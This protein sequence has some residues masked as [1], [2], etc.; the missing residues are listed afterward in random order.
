[1]P[2]L[3]APSAIEP[4]C[5]VPPVDA[6]GVVPFEEPAFPEIAAPSLMLPDSV[7]VTTTELS[8]EPVSLYTKWVY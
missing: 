3:P 7:V 6:D 2:K 5:G 1:M 8:D 4:D